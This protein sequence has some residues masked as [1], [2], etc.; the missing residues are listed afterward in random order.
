MGVFISYSSKDKSFVERLSNKLVE[1][2]VGVWLDKWEMKPGDSLIDKIQSGL[3]DSSYLLVVLSNNYVESEW[4]KKEQNA[5]LIKEINSKQVVVIPILLED[6]TIPIF[7][8][9]KV[10]ADF[11]DDFDMGFTE[12][13][14]SLSAIANEHMGRFYNNGLV[15]DFAF[16][17]GIL[18][19]SFVLYLDF[20]NFLD[21]AER[22]FLLQVEIKGNDVATKRFIEQVEMNREWLMPETV[23]LTL[24]EHPLLHSLDIRIVN[25]QP[26]FN[27]IGIK[28]IS[29]EQIFYVTI[30]GVLM[31]KDDGNDVLV[32]FSDY[33][34]NI[35]EDRKERFSGYRK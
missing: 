12:L 2:R 3:E 22:T 11:R 19:D 35:M 4:C 1:N 27:R 25:D 8:Q 30:R 9:E 29:T 18:D 23:L 34:T 21:K 15:V 20:I 14:R 10:Y 24:H 32:H 13:F 33:T 5:G 31:G 7:L 6:C 17:W 28:D 16:N 26:Y